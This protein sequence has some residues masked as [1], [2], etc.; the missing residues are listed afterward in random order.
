MFDIITIGSAVRDVFM[1]DDSFMVVENEKFVEGKAARSSTTGPVECFPLDSKI[2][3][4]KIVFTTGGGAT[5][6][7]VTFVRQGYNTACIAVIGQDMEGRN[8]IHELNKEGVDT[9]LFQ[10]HDD[11]STSYSVVLVHTSGARTVLNYKGEA[12]HLDFEKLRN[13]ANDLQTK[14]FYLGAVG[15]NW[16][17]LDFIVEHAKNT[18]AKLAINT[19]GSMFAHGPEALLKLVPS[20]DIFTTNKEEGTELTGKSDWQDIVTELHT[21]T[22]G[23]VSVSDGANGVIVMDNQGKTYKAGIP[24]SPVVERT[25][26][27]DA[28][29]SGIVAELMKHET[30]SM[31]QEDITKAIQFG[32]ANAS[33]VV[34]QFGAK[35]GILKK[36]DMGQWP[37][38]EVEIK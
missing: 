11:N 1:Q 14:W 22:N 2:D 33:S 29:A 7:A 26:A 8:I 12:Q 5:N 35:A 3:I 6:S 9:S 17:I 18:G 32:T 13:V 20:I 21:M 10:E 31:N 23:I 34:T 36:G 38:V 27:G 15:G 16:E 19:T 30:L 24:D 37:L 25:G 28:F 4:N